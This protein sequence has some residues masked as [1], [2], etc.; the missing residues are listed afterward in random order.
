[1]KITRAKGLFG[2]QF[3][4]RAAMIF[5]VFHGQLFRAR[6]FHS[7]QQLFMTLNFNTDRLYF[8]ANWL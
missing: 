5:D 3:V 8:L 4:D 6:S 1:M 7:R 2:D